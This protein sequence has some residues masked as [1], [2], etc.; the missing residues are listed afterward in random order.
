MVGPGEV[1]EILAEECKQECSKYGPVS[2]CVVFEV[3]GPC[4]PEENV[5]TFVHFERQE[6]AVKAYRDM[7]GRFFGGRQIAASFYDEDKF[8]KR[9]LA[10][11]VNEW[12]L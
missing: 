3:S 11:K 6:S 9:D 12:E 8:G 1:D 5:R 2:T 7:N 4:P 10:P